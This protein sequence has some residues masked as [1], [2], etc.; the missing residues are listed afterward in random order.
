MAIRRDGIGARAHDCPRGIVLVVLVIFVGVLGRG[1]AFPPHVAQIAQGR[2]G[3]PNWSLAVTEALSRRSFDR[4]SKDG[5]LVFGIVPGADVPLTQGPYLGIVDS[6]AMEAIAHAGV[7]EAHSDPIKGAL[8]KRDMVEICRYL[9][10]HRD[11]LRITG[12]NPKAGPE[13]IIDSGCPREVVAPESWISLDF[14]QEWLDRSPWEGGEWSF[15][16]YAEVAA[17]TTRA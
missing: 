4:D 1:F 9:T 12:P 11:A 3:P 17:E 7:P 6:M 8:M 5:A 15:P 16:D 2:S 14:A 10:E 13:W